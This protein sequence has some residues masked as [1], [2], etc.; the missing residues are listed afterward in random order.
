MLVAQ[1]E[2]PKAAHTEEVVPGKAATCTEPGLTDGAKCTV[3]GEATV[4][5]EEIEALGHSWGEVDGNYIST[6]TACGAT[7]E[8]KPEF[9]ITA[10]PE[11]ATATA[12]QTA[13]F[14]V[15][16]QGV[17]MSYCWRYSRD[18]INW[19]NTTMEGHSTDTL[20][21]PALVSRNGYQYL[22]VI[23]DENGTQ[24]TS[25]IAVLSVNAAKLEVGEPESVTVTEG[26]T[27]QFK[28]DNV[29]GYHYRWQYSRNGSTWY[30]T[31]MEGYDT[32]T[33]T[34]PAPLSR[35]GYRY[36][37]VVTDGFGSE[38]ITTAAV[39]TVNRSYASIV[40]GPEDATAVDGK[41]T[42]QVEAEGNIDRYQWYYSRND[43]Q[44]WFETKMTGCYTDTLTVDAI[45]ARDGY[46]YKVVVFD[47]Y[48]ERAESNPVELTVPAEN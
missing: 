16:A 14:T 44:T 45:P 25:E 20:S 5:Q 13:T 27:V 7:K 39:L 3:C 18:G 1:E 4:K 24:L 31:T 9:A 33:L 8:V 21:V 10:Q 22:C 32:D 23:T 40:K 43:G 38:V 41:A 19:Y 17:N 26:A 46:M 15:T 35:N 28:V 36:R 48:G 34:V 42:F 12:G 47:V 29:E 37:C 6:C 11:D 2:L 30:N